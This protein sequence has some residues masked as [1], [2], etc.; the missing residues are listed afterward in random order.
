MGASNACATMTDLTFNDSH[1]MP[2]LGLGTWKL[3]DA[4]APMVVRRALDTGY[5][6]IDTAAI[7]GNERG[8]GDGVRGSEAFVTTKL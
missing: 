1:T 7:Y 5:R 3:P 2:R 4:Q 6:L 8:V